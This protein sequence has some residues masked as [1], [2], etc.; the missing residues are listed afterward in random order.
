MTAPQS[1]TSLAVTTGLAL[2]LI[3]GMPSQA[4]AQGRTPIGEGPYFSPPESHTHIEIHPRPLL[5]RRFKAWYEL[6]H[7]PSGTVLF[8]EYRCWWVRG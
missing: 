3:F 5:Y 8:P 1:A 6:Q 2:L 7:R 4:T